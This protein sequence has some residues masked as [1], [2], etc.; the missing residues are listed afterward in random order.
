MFAWPAGVFATYRHMTLDQIAD[1]ANPGA[2]TVAIVMKLLWHM[3]KNGMSRGSVWHLSGRT[4]QL[5]EMLG[6][7]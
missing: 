4:R 2:P 7:Q 5:E 3:F 6:S 1:A